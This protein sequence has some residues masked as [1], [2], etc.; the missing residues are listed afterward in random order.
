MTP[1]SDNALAGRAAVITGAA[2][3]IGAGIAEAILEA[4]G[5]VAL[6]DLDRAASEATAR[7][8]DPA[9]ARTVSIEA[10][11]TDAASIAQAAAIA[12]ARFGHLW[13]WVNNAGIVRM[14]PATSISPADFDSEFAVNVRGVLAGAQAAYRAFAGRGGAI[15]NIASNAGKVGFPNM[16]AYNA[17][18]AAVINLTRS[19]SR[20]WASERINVNA[21]CPGSVATPM[22]RDVADVLSKTTGKDSATLFAGMVPAQLCRH[23]EP[24]EVGRI[25]AFLLSDA[26]VIIRGQSI[27]VD[28][29]DT[30]Y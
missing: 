13:G 27:N 30:P 3:G 26:A 7:R 4:G 22:L 10:D 23:V 19:L 20:E 28:A 24:I 16:A 14:G 15:V 6:L 8:L 11:V 1:L 12:V 2:R 18:K 29:G 21:V 5:S 25:V 9:A 17:S